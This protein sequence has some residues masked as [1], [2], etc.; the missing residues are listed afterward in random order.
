LFPHLFLTFSFA[1]L[2]KRTEEVVAKWIPYYTGVINYNINDVLNR[3]QNKAKNP[4]TTVPKKE[5]ILVLPYLEVQSKIATKEM[6]TCI[7]KF[8][9]CINLRVIFQSAY[10]IKSL[11]PCKDRINRSQQS[12]VV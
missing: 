6:K 10:R 8:Y 12:K 2:F 1:H 7:N 5:I 11:F 9:G 4:T 3:H